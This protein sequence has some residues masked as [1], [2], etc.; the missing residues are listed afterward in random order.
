VPTE[1]DVFRFF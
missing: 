1:Q